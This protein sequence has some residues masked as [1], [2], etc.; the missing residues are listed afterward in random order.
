MG[1]IHRL[2]YTAALDLQAYTSCYVHPRWEWMLLDTDVSLYVDLSGILFRSLR[3][4][5]ELGRSC[6]TRMLGWPSLPM[7]GQRRVAL[8]L[9]ECARCAFVARKLRGTSLSAACARWRPKP[10]YAIRWRQS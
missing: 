7:V 4:L 5:G 6:C 9:C 3:S 10:R 8:N 1:S 2:L